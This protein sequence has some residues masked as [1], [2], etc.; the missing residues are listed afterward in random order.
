MHMCSVSFIQKTSGNYHAM[1]DRVTSS[2]LSQQALGKVN[3][4]QIPRD[5]IRALCSDSQVMDRDRLS[6]RY[7][8]NFARATAT[9]LIIMLHYCYINITNLTTTD[10]K[11]KEGLKLHVTPLDYFQTHSRHYTLSSLELLNNLKRMDSAVVFQWNS[12]EF[13]IALV[14]AHPRRCGFPVSLT[15]H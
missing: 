2:P 11:S 6:A 15:E 3:C 10:T 14:Q 4:P 1:S 7:Q 8:Y 12:P 5:I 13:N 9:R